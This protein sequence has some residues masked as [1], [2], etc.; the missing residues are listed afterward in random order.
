MLFIDQPIIHYNESPPAYHEVCPQ[1]APQP[2]SPI[3]D[4]DASNVIVPET[5]VHTSHT[6]QIILSP[7]VSSR[8]T[9]VSCSN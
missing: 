8:L 5:N 9:E 2:L 3:L 4:V 1:F 7:P 6:Q